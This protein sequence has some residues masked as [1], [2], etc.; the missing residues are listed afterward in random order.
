MDFLNRSEEGVVFHQVFFLS[1]LQCTLTHC[2]NCKELRE[3]EKYIYQSKA[4]E[5]TL[6][7]KE[8]NS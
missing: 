5:L 4:L 3:L 7:C 8:E 2:K 1:C 6:N